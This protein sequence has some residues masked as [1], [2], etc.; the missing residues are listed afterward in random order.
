MIDDTTRGTNDDVG[1]ALQA[2]HLLAVILTTAQSRHF[3]ATHEL[4]VTSEVDSDLLSQLAGRSQHENL[5]LTAVKIKTGQQRQSKGSGLAGTGLRLA[6][7]V[8]PFKQTRDGLSL[9]GGRSFVAQLLERGQDGRQQGKIAKAIDDGSRGHVY[10]TPKWPQV[11]L[12]AEEW[13]GLNRHEA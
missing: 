4:T 12:A 5:R 13:V 11:K 6:D 2:A 10:L 7:H 3:Q 9:N 8:T 1:A